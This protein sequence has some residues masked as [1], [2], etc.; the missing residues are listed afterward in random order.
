MTNAS[1]DTAEDGSKAVEAFES[2][3]EGY[4]DLILMDIQMPV[5]D[6]YAAAR[7]IRSSKRADAGSVRI[8]AMTANTFAEDVAR[9]RDAG[10]DGHLAKP[11]DIPLLMQVLR[12]IL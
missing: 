1:V 10:M 7:A 3:G 5:M 12:Q 8:I 6:G 9:A 11:V 2:A 4:Y